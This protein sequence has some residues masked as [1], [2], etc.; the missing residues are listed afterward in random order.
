MSIF[1]DKG[2]R[3]YHLK[4]CRIVSSVYL[5]FPWQIGSKPM[6]FGELYL[7]IIIIIITE[8]LCKA[9]IL[10]ATISEL[11]SMLSLQTIP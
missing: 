1:K 9:G 5:G 2:E 3:W 8:P 11:R 6:I 10:G 4:C 7:V